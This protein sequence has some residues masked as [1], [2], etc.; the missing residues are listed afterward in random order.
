MNKHPTLKIKII[1]YVCCTEPEKDG[2]DTDSQQYDLSRQR[3]KYVYDFLVKFGIKRTR[4]I[5]FGMGG[6]DKIFPDEKNE[7]EKSSNRRI[8][9]KIVS[10]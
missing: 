6:K 9:I 3:A 5:F 8:E 1:G 10:F 4:M 2:L 7:Y